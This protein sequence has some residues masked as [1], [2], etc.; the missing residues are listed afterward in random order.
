[1]LQWT[2]IALF[3]ATAQHIGSVSARFNSPT[4]G[5]GRG[6]YQRAIPATGELQEDSLRAIREFLRGHKFRLDRPIAVQDIYYVVTAFRMSDNERLAVP[7]VQV[8][9]S[10]AIMH[11]PW[12]F[13][14]WDPVAVRWLSFGGDATDGLIITFDDPFE[15]ILGSHTFRIDGRHL[16]ATH[17]D[18]GDS[19]R[20]AEL[21]D[22]EGDGKTELI[23]Y[24]EDPSGGDCASSCHFALRGDRFDLTAGWVN[25]SEWSGQ[26]WVGAEARYPDFYADLADRYRAIGDWLSERGE[27]RPCDNLYW[28]K[29]RGI[30]DRWAVRAAALAEEKR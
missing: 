23:W 11:E 2:V 1:M 30:F 27:F 29:D 8:A 21:R 25:V 14:S 19:C 4:P 15:G 9:D 5:A 13:G 28:L 12:Q 17:H 3:L 16:M 6:S 26:E 7:V 10:F 24:T 20:P 22:L 18:G